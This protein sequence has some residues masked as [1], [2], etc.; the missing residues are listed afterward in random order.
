MGK[1]YM[2]EV[3]LYPLVSEKGGTPALSTDSGPNPVNV[4]LSARKLRSNIHGLVILRNTLGVG[5]H[6]LPTALAKA[7]TSKVN[8]ISERTSFPLPPRA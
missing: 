5:T 1:T 8:R 3:T 4:L 7:C 2:Y 6:H